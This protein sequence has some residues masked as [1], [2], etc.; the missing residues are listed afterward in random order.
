MNTRFLS[1]NHQLLAEPVAMDARTP[2]ADGRIM[3]PDAAANC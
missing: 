3:C 1:I 2:D